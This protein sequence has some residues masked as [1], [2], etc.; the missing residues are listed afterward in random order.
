M[1]TRAR[2]RLPIAGEYMRHEA[3]RRNGS[4]RPDGLLVAPCAPRT[5]PFAPQTEPLSA[6][7]ARSSFA[8]LDEAAASVRDGDVLALAGLAGHLNATGFF[9]SLV[10]RFK[11]TGH[12]RGLTVVTHGGNGGRG[13][14]P[15]TIDDVLALPGCVTRLIAAHIDTHAFAKRRMLDDDEPLE[16]CSR[17]V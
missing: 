9:F 13:R 8:S 12:P 4:M 10:R 5:P 3:R 17:R 14:F 16:V 7:G 11:H 1:D 2:Y 6:P 15:G